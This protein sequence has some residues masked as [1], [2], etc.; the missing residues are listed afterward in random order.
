M[1]SHVV[2]RGACLAAHKKHLAKEKELTR[3]RDPLSRKRRDLPWERVDKAYVF[4][5]SLA[6]QPSPI[7]SSLGWMIVIAGPGVGY[8]LLA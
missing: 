3:L 7:C 5:A 4:E 1:C 2:T 6:G 8:M